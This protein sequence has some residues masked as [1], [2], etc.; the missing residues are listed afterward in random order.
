MLSCSTVHV[1]VLSFNLCMEQIND[2]DAD[3]DDDD[4]DIVK[5]LCK[6]AA[7]Y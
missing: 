5:L 4:D 2:D 7:D 1:A 3:D 6:S